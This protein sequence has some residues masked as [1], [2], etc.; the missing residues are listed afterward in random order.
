MPNPAPPTPDTK[1]TEASAPRPLRVMLSLDAGTADL[2]VLDLAV[3]VA[4]NLC[5]E[6]FG[7]LLENEELLRAA[8]LPFACEIGSASALER[9]LQPEHLLRSLR[10]NMRRIESRLASLAQ[11]ANVQ[12]SLQIERQRRID[13]Q[14]EEE[15]FDVL[16]ME[17]PGG[18]QQ[19]KPGTVKVQPARQRLLWWLDS[20]SFQTMAK[21]LLNRLAQTMDLE[22][23][24]VSNTLPQP[25]EQAL[26]EWLSAH[27]IPYYRLLNEGEPTVVKTRLATLRIH[28]DFAIAPRSLG[29]QYIKQV[30][31]TFPCPLLVFGE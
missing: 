16:V 8:A 2:K 19:R 14:W 24:L 12:W 27:G 10:A 18:L 21:D 26:D 5:G 9:Q 31:D 4:A 30:S 15:T 29:W 11:A 20:G 28:P 22:I 3:T 1:L 25:A 23:Y 6:V 13:T 17:P 7:L